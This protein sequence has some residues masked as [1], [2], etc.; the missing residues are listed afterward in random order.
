[1]SIAERA[2]RLRWSSD[3]SA[4]GFSSEAALSRFPSLTLWKPLINWYGPRGGVVGR[5]SDDVS[6]EQVNVA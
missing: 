3:R 1:M 5:Q 6:V 2:L 4:E